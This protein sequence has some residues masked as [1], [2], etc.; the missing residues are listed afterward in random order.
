MH[1]SRLELQGFKTF[2]K[3]TVVTFPNAAKNRHA[4]TVIVGP[5]G[6]GKSNIADAIRWCLGEQ[7]MKLLRGRKTED[8]IF[9]GAK[10]RARSGFAEVALTIDNADSAMPVDYSEVTITRRLYRDGESDY[11]LNGKRA[12]L[13][14]IQLLLAEAG[15]GQRSYSVIGQGMIDH[16][17]AASPEE[18]KLFFDD[19]TG[20]RGLQMKRHQSMLKL[21]KASENLV[22]VEL[23]LSEIE[24]R[25]RSLKRMVKRLEKRAVIEDELREKQDEYY[26][27]LWWN[28]SGEHDA[29]ETK[30]KPLQIKIKTLKA[31]LVAGD[32]ELLAMEKRLASKKGPGA[33]SGLPKEYR[34]AQKTLQGIRQNLFEAERD[35]ELAKVRAQSTWSPLPLS[36]IIKELDGILKLKE[37]SGI[38]AILKLVKR[39]R[40]KLTKPQPEDF[41]ADPKLTR[42]VNTAKKAVASA[43]AVLKKIEK[44]MDEEGKTSSASKTEVFEVQRRLRA[45]QQELYA[46]EQKEN[47]LKIELA[48]VETRSDGL[49]SEMREELK[50][51]GENIRAH[52]P[53]S[54]IARPEETRSRILHLKHQLELIGGIDPETIEEYKETN[55]RH[56]FLSTQLKDTHEAIK[57]TEKVIDE[58]DA[59]I[60]KQSEKAFKQI[61]TEFQKYFKVLFGGGSC[62]LV[63]V[64]AEKI[65]QETK[66]T[67]DRA[68]ED[69]AEESVGATPGGCP[70]DEE[71]SDSIQA[72]MQRV[73]SRRDSVTGIEIQATPPGKKLKALNALSGGERALTSIALLSAVMATNPSPFVVLDEVDAALDEANTIRFANILDE[74]RKLTQFIVVTHNRATM[75]RA[76][77]L[78]GVTMG[79]DGVSNLISVSLSEVAENGTARR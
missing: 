63:K 76:D 72:I 45:V 1:L 53:K 20:V 35:L 5:N 11:L 48:R 7:S 70:I 57:T 3:K 46:L 14:D 54:R 66:I 64:K 75:E 50:D 71:S 68:M 39:L 27:T 41:K 38:A 69:A 33:S 40:G 58:L 23:L 28:L 34:D 25:L 44:A 2:A 16:V 32:E 49:L 51:K 61:N 74:L 59:Q 43:E 4:L 55:E 21:R 79:G 31:N 9:T 56:E 18:R 12:R 77:M 22:E 60:R 67:M 65:K 47:T 10:G 73:K 13:Q 29:I 19:A 15:V 6:S 62:S 78:Y 24:P 42:K 8:M 37:D 30:L 17:L 52:E 26:R 36:E